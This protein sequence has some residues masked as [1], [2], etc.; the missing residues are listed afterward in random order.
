[1]RYLKKVY[2]FFKLFFS[3]NGYTSIVNVIVDVSG[4]NQG[5]DYTDILYAIMFK[6]Y[7]INLIQVDNEVRSVKFLKILDDLKTIPKVGGGGTI[8]NEGIDFINKNYHNN[9]TILLSDGI[10]GEDVN[11][12]KVNN[13]TFITFKNKYLIREYKE[14]M[15]NK[16]VKKV[17]TLKR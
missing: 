13:F 8:M 17:I 11:F 2:N 9:D 4:S 1:M 12:S 3:L 10:F 14:I 5:E 7:D 15:N 16:D 6:G